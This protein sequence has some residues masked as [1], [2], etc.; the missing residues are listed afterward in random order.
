[1][2]SLPMNI[3][4]SLYQ[5]YVLTV[6]GSCAPNFNLI[7]FGALAT[8][9]CIWDNVSYIEKGIMNG[10][11]VYQ[12]F[13]GHFIYYSKSDINPGQWMVFGYYI[14]IEFLIIAQ[15]HFILSNPKKYFVFSIVDRNI[16]LYTVDTTHRTMLLTFDAMQNVLIIAIPGW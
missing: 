2:L 10:R 15:L 14:M 1:M 13:R 9:H 6:K 7:S 12:T 4:A 16:S 8:W 11:K 3:A 5:R